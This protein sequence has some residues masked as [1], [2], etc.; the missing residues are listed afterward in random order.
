MYT[1]DPIFTVIGQDAL[2]LR[3]MR[4]W[5]HVTN[6]FGLRMAIPRKRQVGPCLTW[7]GFNFYL[8]AG[9]VTVVPS[10][11]HRAL[12]FAEGIL[13]GSKVT[14]DQYRRFIGLLEHMLLFVGWDRTFMYGLYWN[15][16]RRGN[17]HGPATPMYFGDFQQ[18]AIRRWV[19][20][21]MLRGGCFFLNRPSIIVY[22]HA[23]A[24]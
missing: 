23:T 5:H 14:F 21:L 6:S 17:L 22:P 2:L 3:A 7:L 13:S 15:N 12:T 24:S 16:Y 10:K 20:T 4:V 18:T 11:V 8:P 1:D 19:A 9:V